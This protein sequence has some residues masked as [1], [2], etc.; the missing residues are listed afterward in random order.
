MWYENG[1]DKSVDPLDQIVETSPKC[2]YI[3]TLRTIT[4]NC[5]DRNVELI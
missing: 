1:T 3:V 4:D 5:F 2:F